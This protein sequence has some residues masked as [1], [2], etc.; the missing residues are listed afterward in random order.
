MYNYKTEFNSLTINN[1]TF[2][3]N[4]IIYLNQLNYVHFIVYTVII[5]T[6]PNQLHFICNNIHTIIQQ[7]A[8]QI[9]SV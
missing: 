7:H 8:E 4:I 9:I 1:L 2:M 6:S 5:R 3:Y